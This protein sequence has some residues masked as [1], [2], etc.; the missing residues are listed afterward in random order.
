M[1]VVGQVPRKFGPQGDV[2]DGLRGALLLRLFLD[3]QGVTWNEAAKASGLSFDRFKKI[4]LGKHTPLFPDVRRI[5]DGTG[6]R[7]KADD[8][9][10]RGLSL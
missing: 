7:F 1:A 3:R 6:F 8:W 9:E 2:M 4:I 10:I 5:E